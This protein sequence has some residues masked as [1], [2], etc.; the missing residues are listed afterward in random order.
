MELVQP[1]APASGDDAERKLP[2]PEVLGQ[3]IFA[4][5]SSAY[6][7]MTESRLRRSV[8]APELLQVSV[9]RS[10]IDGF[11][12]SASRWCWQKAKRCSCGICKRGGWSESEDKGVSAERSACSA[13]PE[14]KAR[15][16][17]MNLIASRMMR[18]RRIRRLQNATYNAGEHTKPEG[19]V[20]N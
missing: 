5:L 10:T 14:R 9:A 12:R 8:D 4:R 2:I 1:R 20:V 7:M 17:S 11:R 13:Y 15:G 19:M 18:W 16:W 3:R 6:K